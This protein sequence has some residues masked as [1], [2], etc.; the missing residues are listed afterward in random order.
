[1]Q[2]GRLQLNH[3]EWTLLASATALLVLILG[4]TWMVHDLTPDLTDGAAR[5][6]DAEQAVV[7]YHRAIQSGAYS[8]AY[9]RM[10]PTWQRQLCLQDFCDGWYGLTVSEPEIRGLRALRPGEVQISLAFL[11]RTP[12][13]LEQMMSGHYVVLFDGD[14]WLLDRVRLVASVPDGKLLT[15]L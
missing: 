13:G 11:V 4:L 6:S 5:L 2:S 12:S 15:S 9:H 3:D 10:T 7:D 8:A 14:N 1:M